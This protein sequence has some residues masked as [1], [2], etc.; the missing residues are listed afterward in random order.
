MSLSNTLCS[1]TLTGKT[2]SKWELRMTSFKCIFY[3]PRKRLF[4]SDWWHACVVWS[5]AMMWHISIN[6]QEREGSFLKVKTRC[7]MKRWEWAVYACASQ[8]LQGSLV[9]HIWTCCI[10][11]CC[12]KTHSPCNQE[13]E[14]SDIRYTQIYRKKADKKQFSN[15]II[16]LNEVL[17]QTV[18]AYLILIFTMIS[19]FT[20]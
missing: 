6:Q 1:R 8:V 14:S 13:S 9:M 19:D 18:F 17:F 12:D 3:P 7:V 16:H 10:E 2:S 15:L 20:L 5:I 11:D 4:I